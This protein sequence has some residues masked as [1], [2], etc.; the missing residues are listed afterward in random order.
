MGIA[1]YVII[2]LPHIPLPRFIMANRAQEKLTKDDLPNLI[3]IL[4]PVA[5]KSSEL[6]LQL[7]VKPWLINTIRANNR[8]DCEAQ[9]QKIV[10]E[11]LN[12]EQPLTWRDLVKALRS[13]SVR[14]YELAQRI[15]SQYNMMSQPSLAE[16]NNAQQNIALPLSRTCTSDHTH[17]VINCSNSDSPSIRTV[18][19]EQH[20]TCFFTTTSCCSPT[21]PP[22]IGTPT[23]ASSFCSGSAPQLPQ[24]SQVNQTYQIPQPSSQVGYAQQSQTRYRNIMPQIPQVSLAVNQVPSM[25]SQ[26]GSSQ[27]PQTHYPVMLQPQPLHYPR[28]WISLPT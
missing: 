4:T 5:S 9:L 27:L 2:F 11:R 17:S 21:I 23:S 20:P 6:G 19:H 14:A 8:N 10:E 28:G 15:E 22:F 3:N 1:V 12:Q 26:V 25:S 13:D 24:S 7:W 16:R 18:H